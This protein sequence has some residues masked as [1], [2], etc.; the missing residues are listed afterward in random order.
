[1]SDLQINLPPGLHD[2]G[3]ILTGGAAADHVDVTTDPTASA[4][5]IAVR[6]TGGSFRSGVI[7]TPL[8][9][10]GEGVFANG[11]VSLSDV[12]ITSGG[13]GLDSTGNLDVTLTRAEISA[14]RGVVSDGNG[15]K[16]SDVAIDVLH[17]AL[18]IPAAGLIIDSALS[19]GP[20]S[21]TARNVSIAGNLAGSYGVYLAA[22]KSG[23]TASVTMTDSAI[24][25]PPTA[26]SRSAVAGATA[27]LTLSHDAYPAGNYAGT[28]AGTTTVLTPPVTSDPGFDGIGNPR[29]GAGSPLIDAG[30]PGPLDA[31]ESTTDPAG[32]PRLL[33]GNHDCAPRRDIGAYE[34]NDL[35][36]CLSQ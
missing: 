36:P 20:F 13:T 25:G 2:R 23:E 31:G 28:G 30:T 27:N 33:D 29:I 26:L 32:N 4:S 9:D 3:L 1:M 15:V 24:H 5:V 14:P 18:P 21:I 16:L 6:M 19:S 22:N 10:N 7:G 11:G 8:S 35:R 12:S 34:F 17:G